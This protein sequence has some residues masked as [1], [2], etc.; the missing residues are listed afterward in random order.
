[1]F[2]DLD[3]FLV[4]LLILVVAAERDRSLYVKELIVLEGP[5]KLGSNY[6]DQSGTGVGVRA[7]LT[8]PDSNPIRKRL[9]FRIQHQG[10]YFS[11]FCGR[12]ERHQSACELNLPTS[13]SSRLVSPSLFSSC[14]T[15]ILRN[16]QQC[17]TQ[18]SGSL[19]V[20]EIKENI[21]SEAPSHVCDATWFKNSCSLNQKPF[22][23]Q[24]LCSNSGDSVDA[25]CFITPAINYRP[26]FF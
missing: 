19:S 25:V 9:I 2:F 13:F 15:I 17:V 23:L 5:A 8:D 6:R 24:Y 12:P 7:V 22:L 1:M 3:L 11:S 21:I 4:F 20:F 16:I 18:P 26:P 10:D 14:V